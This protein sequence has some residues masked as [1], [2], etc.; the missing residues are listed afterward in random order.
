MHPGNNQLLLHALPQ[1][2]PLALYRQAFHS[3][4]SQQ[5]IHKHSVGKP[6]SEEQRTQM[7]PS[8]QQQVNPRTF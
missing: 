4:C 8:T 2:R 7:H 3:N 6:Q 1:L 5:R